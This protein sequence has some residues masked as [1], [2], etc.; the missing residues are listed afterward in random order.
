MLSCTKL[1][2]DIIKVLVQSGANLRL[3]NKDGWNCFHVA[4]RYMQMPLHD[5]KYIN[6]VSIKIITI[7][8]VALSDA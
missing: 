7:I 3:T 4:A 1:N 8:V 5:K 6:I 2:I